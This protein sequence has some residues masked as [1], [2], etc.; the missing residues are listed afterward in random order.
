MDFNLTK[1]QELIRD[2]MRAFS[3]KHVAPIAKRLDEEHE[4]PHEVFEKLKPLGFL[5]A[6]IPPEYGGAGIDKVAYLLGLEELAYACASTSVT[7]GVHTSVAAEPILIAG[8]DEQ[9]KRFLPP[10][11]SGEKVGCFALT[12]P[13]AGSDVAA[14]AT[15]AKRDG[16]SYI[17]NG[18]KVFI[19]N[20]SHAGQYIVA[21]RTSPDAHRGI[22]LFVV[23]RNTPGLEIGGSEEKLGLRGS[24]TARLSFVDMRVDADRLLGK[25]GDG[26]KILMEV[27]NGS[28]L[29]IAAQAL[30]I[31]RR[32]LDESISYA[33]SRKQFGKPLAQHQ[34]IQFYIANM[35]T[36]LEAARLLT[37][38]AA[39]DEDRGELKPETASMAKVVA[40]DLAEWATIKAVQIHGGNGYIRDYVVE[41]LMRDARITQ[42]YEGTNEIQRLI[43]GRALTKS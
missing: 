24:D 5:G 28:R 17:L 34:I 23:D 41:R 37:L 7:I 11:A 4:F 27:L 30:G 9:K 15:T 3:K 13:G 40:S 14:L 29:G 39:T 12:E 35:A 10:L 20:G 21:A 31:T 2:T 16:R 36:R 25:E 22:S 8:T 42:I 1:E 33:K 38:K 26:F 43:I 19:T 18:A 32:A 6:R